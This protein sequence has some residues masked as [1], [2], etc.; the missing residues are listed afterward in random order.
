MPSRAM[1][2]TKATQS[3]A[4]TNQIRLGGSSVRASLADLEQ[5][6]NL[7]ELGLLRAT[8]HPWLLEHQLR[9]KQT[10]DQQL[11]RSKWMTFLQITLHSDI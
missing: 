4:R 6:E 11:C 1:P 2:A 5:K 7:A 3:V 9:V 8:W 10:S